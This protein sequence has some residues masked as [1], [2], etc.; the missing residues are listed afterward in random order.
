[1]NKELQAKLTA[2][3]E[4]LTL[5]SETG[6][7]KEKES[8]NVTNAVVDDLVVATGFEWSE[9]A[10]NDTMKTLALNSNAVMG[11]GAELS[12]EAFASGKENDVHRVDVNFG[13]QV[14]VQ[15]NFTREKSW[16]TRDMKSGKETGSVTHFNSMSGGSF[17]VKGAATKTIANHAKEFG[18]NL[19]KGA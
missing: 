2:R 4:L 8:G 13:S 16:P 7:V 6:V 12:A 17:T 9:K 10:L 19:L 18:N 3:K 11:A 1:M 15:A 5:D 14:N